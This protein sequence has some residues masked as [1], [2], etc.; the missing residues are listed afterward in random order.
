MSDNVS[1]VGG[2]WNTL[3]SGVNASSGPNVGTGMGAG[4]GTGGGAPAANG[5]SAVNGAAVGN[6]HGGVNGA[7][8]GNGHGAGRGN[9]VRPGDGLGAGLGGA[10]LGAGLGG[11]GGWDG[12]R[13]PT[14]GFGSLGGGSGSAV[15]YS[16]QAGLGANALGNR[17]PRSQFVDAA[18]RYGG[19]PAPTP[20]NRTAVGRGR[21]DAS[22][23]HW[24]LFIPVIVPL[25]PVLYNRVEP[26]LGGVPFFYWGQLAFALLS[27]TVVTIVHLATKAR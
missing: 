27:T 3:R 15:G 8:V 1:G 25:V 17:P 23:W 9:G 14:T 5:R 21:L 16:N 18:D 6:G 12:G 19:L 13:R 26:T 22:P 7:A 24:L 10:G 11:S 20:T 2:G 4:N